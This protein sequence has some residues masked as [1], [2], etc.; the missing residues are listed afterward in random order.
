MWRAVAVAVLAI[1][2]GCTGF[3][4][5]GDSA[6]SDGA[7]TPA[8]VPDATTAAVDIPRTNGTVDID[9]VIADHD[10]ALA[11]RSF[12]RRVEQDDV[13]RELWVDHDTGVVRV[14]QQ[15]AAG[16]AG[17]VVA[18]GTTYRHSEGTDPTE[19]TVSEGGS[20]VPYVL[21]L[22]GA[23]TLR[24]FF[25]RYEY[26]Q[27]GTVEWRGRPVAVLEANETGV[28]LPS[29]NPD[30]TVAVRSQVYVDEDGVIRYVVH[31]EAFTDGTEREI[32]MVTSPDIE[33]VTVPEWLDAEQVYENETS[34]K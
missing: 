7:V 34:E 5:A 24:Q 11:D 32:R 33:R 23:T 2:A 28:P 22:S 12:Y 29:P 10:A 8:P 27:V 20:D 25:G 18:D 6:A 30:L 3:V 19:Y 16:T 21:S 4:T 1:M 13:E 31:R 17:A 14:Q 15:S 26:R 9:R